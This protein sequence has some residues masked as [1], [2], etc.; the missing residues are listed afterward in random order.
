MILLIDP[1]STNEPEAQLIVDDLM[2]LLEPFFL[3]NLRIQVIVN[4]GDNVITASPCLNGGLVFRALHVNEIT[5]D[6]R[7]KDMGPALRSEL[8]HVIRIKAV[9]DSGGPVPLLR[10]AYGA[11]GGDAS[12]RT[13]VLW[14]DMLA[15][16]GSCLDGS[17]DNLGS[18][19]DGLTP[20]ADEYLANQLVNRC[21]E[22]GVL[23]PDGIDGSLVIIGSGE[24]NR[25]GQFREFADSLASQLCQA[26]DVP[27]ERL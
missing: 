9:G 10:Y 2:P 1:A 25:S 26:I 5:Q 24:T 3:G 17:P 11:K 8:L 4:H 14:S 15:N 21:V 18:I 27:C 22:S 19:S 12:T 13:V 16:D 7:V 6:Q 23:K 20:Y